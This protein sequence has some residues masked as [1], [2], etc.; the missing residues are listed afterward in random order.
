MRAALSISSQ[1]HLGQEPQGDGSGQ[2]HQAE[3]PT[4]SGEMQDTET[5]RQRDE[6]HQDEEG[7]R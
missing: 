5:V 4:V 6:G 2:S 3:V 7:G 1:K